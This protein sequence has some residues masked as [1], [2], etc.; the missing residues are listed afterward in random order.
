MSSYV[1]P[2]LMKFVVIGGVGLILL[3]LVAVSVISLNNPELYANTPFYPVV[4][5]IKENFIQTKDTKDAK[6]NPADAA[7]PVIANVQ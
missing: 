7:G 5:R 2:L 6:E 3:L 1:A 4:Q